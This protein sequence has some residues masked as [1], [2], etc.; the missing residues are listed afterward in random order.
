MEFGQGSDS[1]D[2]VEGFH[3]HVAKLREYRSSLQAHRKYN[4]LWRIYYQ[5]YTIADFEEIIRADDERRFLRP[6]LRE[7]IEALIANPGTWQ[8]VADAL[9]IS[10]HTAK[11][12]IREAVT[13]YYGYRP[14]MPGKQER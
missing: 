10:V 11:D 7:G 4:R 12:R 8:E 6:K 3:T 13:T 5:Q 9:G 2:S 1:F 14:T